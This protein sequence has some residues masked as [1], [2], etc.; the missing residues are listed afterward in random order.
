MEGS[1]A[2]ASTELRRRTVVITGAGSGIGQAFALGFLADGADVVGGDIEPAGLTAVASAGGHTLQGD[3]SVD[4]NVRAL[5]DLA[6]EST[7]RVDVLINNAGYGM[8]TRVEDLADGEFEKMIAVHL[9]GCIY[10]MRAAIPHMRAQEYG[11]IIN[12]ISR[13]AEGNAGGNSA[14][15]AAKAGMWTASR[16]AAN[17]TADTDI[18]VNM[19]FPGMTNTGIWGVDMPGMQDPEVVYPTAKMLATLPAGGP[20]GTVFYREQPYQMFDPENV[21]MLEADRDEIRRRAAAKRDQHHG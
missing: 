6:I 8:Q 7:G 3:V 9:F 16:S 14:Y 2:M 17:E 15:G 20:T 11:R 12:V 19:L 1:P 10:G 4:A 21:K 18:L 5:V 13:A